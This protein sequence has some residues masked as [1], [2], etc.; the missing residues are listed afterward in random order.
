[1]NAESEQQIA[2]QRLAE[3]LERNLANKWEGYLLRSFDRQ[4]NLCG[5]TLTPKQLQ[6]ITRIWNTRSPK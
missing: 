4:A 2:L 3:L 1:M 5:A 6:A